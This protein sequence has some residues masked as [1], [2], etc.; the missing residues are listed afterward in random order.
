MC[1]PTNN[2]DDDDDSEDNASKEGEGGDAH[3]FMA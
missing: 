3:A 2:A 1:Q